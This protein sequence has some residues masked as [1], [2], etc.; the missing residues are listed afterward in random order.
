MVGLS[1]VGHDVLSGASGGRPIEVSPF[2]WAEGAL[3]GE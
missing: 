1:A 2:P 3:E